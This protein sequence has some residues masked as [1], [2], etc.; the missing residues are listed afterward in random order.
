MVVM[1]FGGKLLSNMFRK[2]AT[3]MYPVVQREYP[4][5]S[6]GHVEFHPE[7][8]ITCNICG[9]KCPTHAITVDKTART[10]TIDRMN[11]IQCGYCVE[12]CPKKCLTINPGYTTP[13][14]TKNS[15]TY[16]VPEKPKEPA[17]TES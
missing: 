17:K 12:S 8:C 11:C 9:R 1:R 10:L 7:N 4:E 14:Y 3:K 16:Q 13:D 5:R 15:D 2:P 6:R